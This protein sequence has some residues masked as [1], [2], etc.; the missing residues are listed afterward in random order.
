MHNAMSQLK[1]ISYVRK[2]TENNTACKV[3]L[4]SYFTK[5][6]GEKYG[7]GTPIDTRSTEL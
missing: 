7:F 3:L 2:L 6:K 5:I 4:V 1:I